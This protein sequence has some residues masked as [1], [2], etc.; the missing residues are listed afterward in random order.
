MDTVWGVLLAAVIVV[1]LLLILSFRPSRDPTNPTVWELITKG[2]NGITYRGREMKCGPVD[3]LRGNCPSPQDKSMQNAIDAADAASALA[4][5]SAANAAAIAKKYDNEAAA[6]AAANAALAAAKA[7]EASGDLKKEGFRRV[8]VAAALDQLEG[9]CGG[10]GYR[11]RLDE[12]YLTETD[13]L[14]ISVPYY[15]EK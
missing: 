10:T 8:P 4:A 12:H 13:G 11:V 2:S 1:L 15:G 14:G 7:A 3:M 5:K 6:K 9:M